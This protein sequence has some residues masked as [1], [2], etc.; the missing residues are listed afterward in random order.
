[1]PGPWELLIIL[2]IV[3]LV[4]GT[5][6]LRNLGSDV[7]SIVKGYQNAMKGDADQAEHTESNSSESNDVIE[8][9]VDSSTDKQA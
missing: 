4:F 6:K 7:G 8:G 1:M 5:K 2:A 9:E 3:A